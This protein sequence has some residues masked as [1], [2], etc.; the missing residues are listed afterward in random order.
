MFGR[1][2]E[3]DQQ[4]GDYELWLGDGVGSARFVR[5][6]AVQEARVEVFGHW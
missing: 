2:T 1:D 3:R 4:P 5:L 6:E